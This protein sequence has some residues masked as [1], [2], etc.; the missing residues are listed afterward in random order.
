M[1]FQYIGHC[2]AFVQYLIT[3]DHFKF[4]L[5]PEEWLLLCGNSFLILIYWTTHYSDV[6]MGAMASQITSLTIVYSTVSSGADEKK[7]GKSEGF[8]SCDR[9][10]ILTFRLDSNRWFFGPCDQEIWWKSSKNN[11]APLLYSVKL[12]ASFQ[13][14]RWI[15]TGVAVRKRQ[16][17]VKII[18][19]FPL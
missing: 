11:R 7:Q 14:H 18:E 16:I 3:V 15:Q 17:W 4:R 5:Q 9:P 2:L 12:C 19:F 6:I 13:S 10:C 8:D 1:D